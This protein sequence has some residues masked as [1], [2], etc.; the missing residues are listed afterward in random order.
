[1]RIVSLLPSA[2]DIVAALGAADELVG[3]SHSCDAQWSHLPRLTSTLIDLGAPASVIDATVKSSTEPLYR[4]DVAR[5]EA[6][7]PEVVVSQSLCDVC[8]VDAGDVEQAVR[9]ISSRPQLV[10]LAPFG[11]AD[12]PRGFAEVGAAIGRTAEA[13]ELVSRWEATCSTYQNRFADRQPRIAFLDWLDPPYA[14][15]HWI[16]DMIELLGGI[17]VL[18]QPGE[19]SF[20]VSWDVVRNVEADLVIGACCGLA[21]ERARSQP[22]PAGV[23]IAILDGDRLFSRPGPGIMESLGV[24]AGH[25]DG[26]LGAARQISP[27]VRLAGRR[28]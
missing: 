9:S 10:T 22:V 21:R 3:V 27:H 13:A 14:A 11:L 1:M 4:L 8:A 20:E 24:L 26:G 19:P 12:I 5:L 25:I 7:A 16:P 18:A 23:A 15:G 17:S 6:L 28:R 2:T